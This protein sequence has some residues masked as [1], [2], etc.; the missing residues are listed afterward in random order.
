MAKIGR[1]S[2][3]SEIIANAICDEIAIG[4]S[5]LQ[6]ANDPNY[7]AE[8]TIYKWLQK[9]EGFRE[10]YARA[11]EYQAEH[12]ASEIIHLADTP[13]EARKI[14]IKPDGSEEIV[15]GDAVERSRLQIDA[16]KW[17]ASKVAPKVYGDKLEHT[18]SIGIQTVMLPTP[19]KD[20]PA[21]TAG[22]PEWED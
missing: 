4:R 6:I 12:Y 3:Y 1:P 13:V 11:R 20:A 9:H 15:I 18:G 14:T 5:V 22:E 21:L 19:T 2:D 8:G 7:P 17:Y 10:K 16:R